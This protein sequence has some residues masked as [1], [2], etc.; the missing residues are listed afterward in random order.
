MT[1]DKTS[2]SINSSNGGFTL[3]E[4]IAAAFIMSI[5]VILMLTIY[6]AGTQNYYRQDVMATINNA[7]GIGSEYI[8]ADLMSAKSIVSQYG[9]NTTSS[10]IVVIKAPAY[11]NTGIISNTFD[12]ISYKAS[13]GK[14]L[15]SIASG[16]GLRQSETNRVIANNISGLTFT[17]KCFT[18]FQ[19]DGSTK[20]FTVTHT[21]TS[22]PLVTVN[23]NIATSG[24]ALGTDGRSVVFAVAPSS[25]TII[26]VLYPI[27]PADPSSVADVQT[28]EFRITSQMPYQGSTRTG[29]LD[30]SV[31]LRNKR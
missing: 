16:G 10:S 2:Y 15:R 27:S 18:R 25:G 31:R 29:Q 12:Y 13:G 28:V 23:G 30:S 20:T 9:S 14:L 6:V 22:N 21:W 7:I 26:D 11:N 8:T 17:Y 24:Y 3:I 19:G 1:S 4:T 5:L